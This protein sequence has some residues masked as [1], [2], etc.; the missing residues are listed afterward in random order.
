MWTNLVSTTKLSFPLALHHCFLPAQVTCSRRKTNHRK[1]S[2]Y[3]FPFQQHWQDPP[4]ELR[5]RQHTLSLKWRNQPV[6]LHVTKMSSSW[7]WPRPICS[8]YVS[9]SQDEGL[10]HVELAL[11]AYNAN[12]SQSWG[13]H[14]SL[15]NPSKPTALLQEAARTARHDSASAH[16]SFCVSLALTARNTHISVSLSLVPSTLI[17]L[18][19]FPPRRNR[20]IENHLF[21]PSIQSFCC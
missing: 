10:S 1:S 6:L 18:P 17:S 19:I 16:P 20:Y 15:T 12:Q 7:H 9:Q 14:S 3:K 2:T 5:C 13:S 21:S 11:C 4:L 8:G